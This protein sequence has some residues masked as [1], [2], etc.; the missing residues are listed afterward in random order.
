MQT[1]SRPKRKRC[2]PATLNDSVVMHALP[3][4]SSNEQSNS[5]LEI[6]EY[7]EII[8]LV[9]VKIASRFDNPVLGALLALQRGEMTTE[10]S[11]FC[12]LHQQD[13]ETVERQLNFTAM[14]LRKR[15]Q[16]HDRKL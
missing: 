4:W 6:N 13:V 9:K 2:Q 10:L 16:Y 12:Q 14:G 5:T 15:S 11:D 8:D 7:Y 1:S 3:T